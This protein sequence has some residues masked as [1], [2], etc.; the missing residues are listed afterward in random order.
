MMAHIRNNFLSRSSHEALKK[1]EPYFLIWITYFCELLE[2]KNSNLSHHRLQVGFKLF[3]LFL[4]IPLICTATDLK[5]WFGNNYETE[6]RATLIYQNYNAISIPHRHSFRHNENDAFM[7]LSATY[8]FK[9]Y[10]GEFEATAAD[11]RYQKYRWDNFRITG[12]YQWMTEAEGDE[13]S[14]VTGLTLTQPYSR[15]LHDISSFHHGH[16]EGEATMSFGQKYGRPCSHDYTFR[17]WSVTG[18]GA[19]DVGSSW[20]REDL[21]CEYNHDDTHELRGFVNTLWGLG[22]K[23]LRPEHFKGYGNINHKS[24]DLGIRYSYTIGCWGTLSIQY[25]RRVYAYNFPENTNLALCEYYFPFGS[26]PSC[27]Y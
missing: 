23:N 19:S 12:R 17:W 22:G 6:I 2:K 9:R 8:P 15:A 5:P 25:A 21:A 26:Q 4:F 20:V 10:S 16:I 3:F 1:S 18:I 14:L 11:T 27:N 7:T 24:V 13:F